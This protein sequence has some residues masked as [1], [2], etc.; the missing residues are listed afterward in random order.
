MHGGHHDRAG[1][2]AIAI[3]AKAPDAGRVKTRLSPVLRAEEA[4]AL[5]ACFLADMT[6]MLARAGVDGYVAYAPAGS[7]A[8]F[9][10][11]VAPGT[12]LV[13]ADG[14]IE[15][16]TG[17]A[18]FGRCLLQAAQ[19]LFARG[20]GAVGLL[21]SDSPN[22]PAALIAEAA[23]LLAASGDR[24]VLGPA[25]DGGYYLLGMKA[26]HAELFAHIDWSTERVAAQTRAAAQRLGLA[27][28]EIAPWY[29]VD[30]PAS[31]KQLVRDLGADGDAAPST[32]EWLY[33]NGTAARLA[34][35]EAARPCFPLS[36]LA[37]RGS[38]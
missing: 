8:S 38:G 31:L 23:R 18:G 29:D 35:V 25:T 34:Q 19:G 5:S 17:V 33:R 20:Y 10:P 13:L 3:M 2:C 16:P 12:G 4:R 30:D 36:P 9:A 28:A 26:P 11:I 1:R 37:G 15:A 7:E 32:A 24:A 6:R 14:S 22:L 21:N 27:L